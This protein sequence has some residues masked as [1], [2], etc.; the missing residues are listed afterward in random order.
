MKTLAA[1][2]GERV[3]W[4]AINSSHFATVADNA[5]FVKEK[6]LPYRVLDDHAGQV[7]KAYGAR[8]TPDM[9]V[10]DPAGK[11]AFRGAIDDDPYGEKPA[12]TNH[13]DQSLAALLGGKPVPVSMNAPYGCTVKYK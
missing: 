9:F 2:Y 4:L 12:P 5:A 13:V 11:V 3:T 10:S 8:T 6:A 1:K 7:G